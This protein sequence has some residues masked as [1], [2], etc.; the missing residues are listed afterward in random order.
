MSPG[1]LLHR[2]KL[3]LKK[4]VMTIKFSWNSSNFQKLLNSLLSESDTYYNEPLRIDKEIYFRKN[5]LFCTFYFCG[6]NIALHT[7]NVSF[8]LRNSSVNVT[9]FTVSCGLGNIY[10]RN[11]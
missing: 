10:R 9:K 3:F 5:R 8:P 2:K 6:S 4:K 7:E 11:P 1:N